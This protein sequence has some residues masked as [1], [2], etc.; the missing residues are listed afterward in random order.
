M[1]GFEKIELNTPTPKKSSSAAETQ[2]QETLPTKSRLGGRKISLGSLGSGGGDRLARLRRLQNRRAYMGAL[3]ILVLFL[4]LIIIPGF[5]TFLSAKKTYAQ[6]KVT[7]AALKKQDIEATDKEL[8]KTRKTLEDTQGKLKLLSVMKFIPG[9]NIYYND[10]T[11]LVKAGFY[12]LDAADVFVESIK[13]YA[14]VLGLKGQGSFVG[15]SAEQRIKTAV[16]TMDKV[17]PRIDDIA[18]SLKQAKVEIDHVNPNDYPGFILGGKLRN[19]MTTL[20]SLSD[21]G[22]AFV[23][24]AKPLI[25]V[26]PSLLGEPTEK[27]Y[28]ILFQNDKELRPTGGFL[29]AYA[30][31]RLN[32]GI[33]HVD[34]SEDIY[35]LDNSIP[36]KE[37][38][39]EPILKYLPKVPVLNL[40]DSNLSPDFQE[41]MKKFREIY[42]DAGRYVDVDG[43]I[44][45][46]THALV[47]AMNIL[48]DVSVNGKTYTTKIDP[49]C[50]CPQVIYE[51]EEFA[52]I[53]VQYIRSDRKSII[54]DLMYAIMNK[55]F[56]SSPKQY[57]GPL[58]QAMF[59]EI[60]QKHVLFSL[61]NKDAQAGFSAVNAGGEIKDFEG[62]YFHLNEANFGGAKSNL[63]TD[64]N[65]VQEYEVSS[66]G[67]ITKTVTVNYKNPSKPSNCNLEAE[68]SLCLNAPWRDWFRVY[69]PKGSKL[70]DSSGSEVKMTS[71]DELGKS[72]FEGF[73]TVRPLGIG[74]L[75][76]IYSLPFKLEKGSPL[77]VLIQ[78]QPGTADDEY[79]IKLNG[80]QIQKFILE[81][82]KTLELKI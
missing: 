53:R 24:E 12:G 49:R 72:V 35:V 30:I 18:K 1:D 78:K 26:L 33:V 61:E 28:L 36:N 56:S 14:D 43:I 34:T 47:A 39:P 74:K 38:A 19:G 79:V 46:D 48:G 6:V 20:R 70:K 5:L 7:I 32:N 31:F 44:A 52:G 3:I 21:D 75:T 40:R 66:D 68:G 82:D 67:T 41:S 25:K 16:K 73:L 22:V 27:K 2:S 11:H 42:A 13:P 9:P 54:G 64:Q 4:I 29:T 63:F 55:A 60:A 17:T 57:W 10:A 45:I 23:D 71:Y 62:D 50:D 69:V 80:K 65:V 81:G 59:G 37:K 58:V 77:P 15:G 51:L 8:K 76:L